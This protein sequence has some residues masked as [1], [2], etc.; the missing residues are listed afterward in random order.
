MIE[1]NRNGEVWIFAEQEDASLNEVSLELVGRARELAD[2]LGVKVGAVLA[3]WN[4]RE[5]SYRLIAHGVD[6]VYHVHDTRL[7]HYRTLPYAR[8]MC[9]LIARHKPQIVMYGATP[10]DATWLRASPPR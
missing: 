4:V 10:I 9:Q 2:K 1:P 7:E 5:L 6:N 8:V 3:G